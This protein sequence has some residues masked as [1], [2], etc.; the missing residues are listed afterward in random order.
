MAEYQSFNHAGE[1]FTPHAHED[2]YF[3]CAVYKSGDKAWKT[4]E[5]YLLIGRERLDWALRQ[6][7]FY[8]RM[9]CDVSGKVS[10]FSV[11]NVHKAASAP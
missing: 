9:R 2:G 6:P 1:R 5:R 10:F 4:R 11:A 7:N 8:I 3:R